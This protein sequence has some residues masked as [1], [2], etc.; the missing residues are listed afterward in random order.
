MALRLDDGT[1][2]IDITRPAQG[3]R[4]RIVFGVEESSGEEVAAKIELIPG[5]LE[6]EARALE[7]LGAH[8]GPAPRLRAAGRVVSGDVPGATC[9][10]CDRAAGESPTTLPAWN[11]LGRALAR[12][13]CVPWQGSGLRVRDHRSFLSVHEARLDD[14]GVTLR[15]D[16]RG[17]L[18]AVPTSYPQAPLV[19]T[20]G[21]PGPGN[22]LDDGVA[23]TLIDWED[24]QVSP[25]GL[26]LGRA[27]F[28]ALIGSGP[29]GYK[30]EDHVG[31]ARSIVTGLLAETDDWSPQA[32]EL[33]W[34]LGV[35]GVQF[36]HHRLERAG[37]S[38]VLPWRDAVEV[39]D[40]AL[41]EGLVEDW[42]R[43]G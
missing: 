30:A 31:R 42:L 3:M 20:H 37:E 12:L 43:P 23:G 22:Y 24:A 32:D 9:I 18:P 19:L 35:A 16:L 29:E 2:I 10:V 28:I 25:R 41:A 7:W 27:A 38:G 14:L 21:D 17:K 40:R 15:S 8:G 33:A 34:W 36:A 1:T 39:L 6:V 4:H 11:R 5:A 26:D 13:E